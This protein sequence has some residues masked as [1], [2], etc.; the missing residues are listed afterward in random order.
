MKSQIEKVSGGYLIV[1]IHLLNSNLFFSVL[2]ALENQR[3]I[4]VET[5]RLQI[6][7][8]ELTARTDKL[9]Q[10]CNSLDTSVRVSHGSRDPS[11]LMC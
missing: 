2:L 11:R 3:I 9:L 6:G 1:L 5:K 8:K 7:A 10:L 4:D